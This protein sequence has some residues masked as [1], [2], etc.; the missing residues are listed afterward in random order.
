LGNRFYNGV[1]QCKK[2]E[3]E[4]VTQGE[5]ENRIIVERGTE[6][7]MLGPPDARKKSSPQGLDLRKLN[8]SC[9]EGVERT[10]QKKDLR[11]KNDLARIISCLGNDKGGRARVKEFGWTGRGGVG[12]RKKEGGKGVSEN[13]G[14]GPFI[15]KWL[16]FPLKKT[17]ELRGGGSP[18]KRGTDHADLGRGTFQSKEEKKK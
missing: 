14:E 1:F 16:S 7:G 9:G 4:G 8:G 5:R 13:F 18:E 6:S 3:R 15:S 17:K 11:L 12:R 10:G 2:S